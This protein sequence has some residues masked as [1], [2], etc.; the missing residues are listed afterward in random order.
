MIS[1]NIKHRSYRIHVLLSTVLV[2]LACCLFKEE[3][4]WYEH[5]STRAEVSEIRPAPASLPVSEGFVYLYI[6]YEHVF[7]YKDSTG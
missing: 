6:I 3:I 1:R 5:H 4:T 2:T 7:F